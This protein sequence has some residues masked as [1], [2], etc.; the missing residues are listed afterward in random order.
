MASKQIETVKTLYRSWTAAQ[1]GN[2][3]MS[4]DERR[5]MMEGWAQL[6]GEPG[7]TDYLEVEA[8]GVSAMWIVPKESVRDRIIL[9]LHGGGFV[10]GSMYTHRKLFGHLARR[11]G[12][13]ALVLDYRRS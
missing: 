2:P 13:R 5:D 8:G 3:N 4:L 9:G 7:R 12:V 11:T 6:T 10:V 1:E